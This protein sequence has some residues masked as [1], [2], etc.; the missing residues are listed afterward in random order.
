MG[1]GSPVWHVL[2][3]KQTNPFLS[4][5]Q[6]CMTEQPFSNRAL[7][8]PK[9]IC[10]VC[11]VRLF[12]STISHLQHIKDPVLFSMG[13]QMLP[14]GGLLAP[15]TAQMQAPVI[16]LNIGTQGGNQTV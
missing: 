3:N 7:A 1:T 11:T 9:H 4:S 2:T 12:S 6:F 14:E 13:T 16:S 8:E 10:M 5:S 15:F